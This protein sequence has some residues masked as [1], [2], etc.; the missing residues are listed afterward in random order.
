LTYVSGTTVDGGRTTYT[1][2]PASS[3]IP[4]AYSFTKNGVDYTYSYVK[5]SD[6]GFATEIY[7][8]TTKDGI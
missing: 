6:G 2:L 8:T 4:S 1:S 3:T 5:T 7:E